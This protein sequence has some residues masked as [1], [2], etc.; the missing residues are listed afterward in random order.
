MTYSALL[1]VNWTN[2]QAK[3][4]NWPRNLWLNLD[5]YIKRLQRYV[6]TTADG[7]SMFGRLLPVY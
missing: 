6:K 3:E 2:E 5:S 4:I 7:L 1:N